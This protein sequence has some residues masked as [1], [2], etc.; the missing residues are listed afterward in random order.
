MNTAPSAYAP[1]RESAAP[2]PVHRSKLESSAAIAFSA[3]AVSVGR[4]VVP[5]PAHPAATTHVSSCSVKGAPVER[6]QSKEPVMCVLR[7]G[8][9]ILL[10]WYAVSRATHARCETPLRLS[11]QSALELERPV[12]ESR[13]TRWLIRPSRE[14]RAKRELLAHQ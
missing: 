14:V 1:V 11:Q 2:A 6:P 4:G 12:R 7:S 9:G 13:L 5:C 8:L 10:S 3:P